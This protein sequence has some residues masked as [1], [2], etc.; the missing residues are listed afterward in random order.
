MT[1]STELDQLLEAALA[2]HAQ[3]DLLRAEALYRDALQADPDSPDALNLLGAL[4]QD[5]GRVAASLPLIQR[6]IELEPEFPEALTHLARGLAS[7]GRYEEAIAAAG[8]AVALDPALAEASHQL[9]IAGAALGRYAQ[10]L[11]ALRRH[12]GAF[13]GAAEALAL[14]AQAAQRAND[15]AAAAE[16]WR[17]LLGIQPDRLDAVLNLGVAEGHLEHLDASLAIL[18]RAV[19]AAPTDYAARRALA[20]TYHRRSDAVALLG[21]CGDLLRDQPDDLDM[22]SL[23]AAAYIW[24]GRFDEASGVCLRALALQPDYA[25][26]QQ[27]LISIRAQGQSAAGA[28]DLS[29]RLLDEALP[30]TERIAA[31]F[32]AGKALEQLDRY[33]AAFQAF[34][35]A[36]RLAHA[37]LAASGRAF[38]RGLLSRY[39]DWARSA[40]APGVFSQWRAFG[41]ATDLP[42][43]VVGMP[44]SG[45]SLVEQIAASHPL[46]HGAGEREEMRAIVSRVGGN[47]ERRPA[48]WDWP[49]A[50][51]ETERYVALLRDLG[52]PARRVID[53][54]PDNIQLLGQISLLF[55]NAKIVVCRRDPRDVCLS[56]FTNNFQDTL[57]WT[58]DL[59]DCAFRHGE[60]L[61]LLNH[62]QQV[63]PPGRVLEVTYETLVANLEA[64]GRR[65]IGF[66]GLD[67]D[68]ACLDFHMTKRVVTTASA[69]QVRQPLYQSSVGRWRRYRAHLGP[70]LAVL[71]DPH[72]HAAASLPSDPS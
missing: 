24:L 69:W 5:T 38:D 63:I 8:R 21:V 30:I 28:S 37:R 2:A 46:V 19:A 47:G 66:L 62:W 71:G 11:D 57:N 25:N 43:F 44:R 29:R 15:H 56:C 48:A 64:E 68:P 55:P 31:G 22:L 65:L 51:A 20:I 12:P 10:A 39:V 41:H 7:L 17:A 53:K 52:G 16:A 6:A 54:M 50:R 40:F 23:L 4:L 61:R 26:A 72:E 33:D 70:M 14:I 13:P 35:A 42:V 1:A 9:G 18:Q 36:N 67:W 32:A 34:D 59:E 45:T 3:D 58:T 49:R 27:Q 60:I